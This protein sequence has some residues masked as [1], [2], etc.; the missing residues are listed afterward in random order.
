VGYDA[1]ASR[2]DEFVGA[3]FIHRLAIPAILSLCAEG[4]AVLD[5]ACGQGALTRE[6]GRRFP[7]VV[8][9]DRSPELIGIAAVRGGPPHVRYLA[10]D[11]EALYSL[12]DA[13]FDGATCCLALT[14]FD[15][16]SAVLSATFRV[17][18]PN[19]WLVV[20]TL[21]PCF[22]APHAANGEHDGRT[23]KLVGNYFEEGRWWPHDRTRL[24]GEIGWHHRTLSSILNSFLRC[25]LCTGRRPG[26]SRTSR[27]DRRKSLL[28]SGRRGPDAPLALARPVTF[29]TR[30]WYSNTSGGSHGLRLASICSQRTTSAVAWPA[31]S[32]RARCAAHRGCLDGGPIARSKIGEHDRPFRGQC[33]SVIRAFPQATSM[34]AELAAEVIP[35]VKH[36][37][38]RIWTPVT[39]TSMV[40]GLRTLTLK[41]RRVRPS[42]SS[43]TPTT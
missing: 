12:A 2:Y 4:D 32:I 24:F 42:P 10:E 28:W 11:A 14:D 6:L 39:L 19:G 30:T 34:F 18:K 27:R 8:G 1:I 25:R 31:R 36:S 16:L 22:E 26:T 43:D 7:T 20:A 23:V 37:S 17:L 35:G 5:V 41:V 33:P 21:H 40:F 9:V 15:D 3:S 13:S 38:V 29:R